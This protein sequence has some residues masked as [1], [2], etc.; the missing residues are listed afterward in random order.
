MS[1]LDA[2]AWIGVAGSL[3]ALIGGF[4]GARTTAVVT[5]GPTGVVP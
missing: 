5:S 2:G 4:F 3:V 1:D